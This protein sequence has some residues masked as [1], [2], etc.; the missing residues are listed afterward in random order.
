[1]LQ[2]A[3]IYV[4]TEMKIFEQFFYFLTILNDTLS[5]QNIVNIYSFFF[6]MFSFL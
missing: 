6:L 5:M 3:K 2:N 4:T 1:M